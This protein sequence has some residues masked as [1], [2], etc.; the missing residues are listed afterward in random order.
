MNKKS[1][2]FFIFLTFSALTAFYL[3][4]KS[5]NGFFFQDDWFSLKISSVKNIR[6]ALNIF[7]PRSDVIYYR[8]LGMQL[9]F[10]LLSLGGKINPIPF[11]VLIAVVHFANICLLSLLILKLTGKKF[12]SLLVS[13]FYSTSLI[14]FTIFWWSA[15][16]SFILTTFFLLI[17]LI[18]YLKY[19][20]EKKFWS[21][22]STLLFFTLA[23]LTNEMALIFP[24]LTLLLL[25]LIK[26]GKFSYLG[27]VPFIILPV[28][29][30]SARF[31]Y[32]P[33]PIS[34]DYR[35]VIDRGLI[36]NL[37]DYF[38]WSFN[39][40]EEMK[41]QFVK[42][43]A[44]N[45]LFISGFKPYFLAFVVTLFINLSFLF[46]IPF[47]YLLISGNLIPFRMIIF[48][49]GLFLAGLLPV[50]LFGR[51]T[52]SYY[53]TLSLIGLL[54]ITSSLIEEF[55]A[56]F[57]GKYRLLVFFYLLVILTNWLYSSF[58][59]FEFNMKVHWAPRRSDISQ[60]LISHAGGL[61]PAAGQ[62]VII[63]VNNNPE[64]KLALNNQD[65]FQVLFGRNDIITVYS[66]K[67]EADFRL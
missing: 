62:T 37:R 22:F 64:V 48:G 21:Y 39:W 32:F 47:L 36:I 24:V 67:I 12:S 8:P 1:F 20:T 42:F 41:G 54:L 15:T 57:E 25:W 49:A 16:L 30:F 9:P 34:G 38:L 58:M 50:I 59:G 31:L 14:H 66:D 4:R 7:V 26:K 56:S 43:F 45:P 61:K 27:V 35:L 29:L 51:H 23:L 28:I 2:V 3:F 19:L 65:A 44:V 55:F 40:P 52:F 63:S 11:K 13:F 10:Y 5:L 33:P 6:D 17:A 18:L 46:L 53:L 60:K